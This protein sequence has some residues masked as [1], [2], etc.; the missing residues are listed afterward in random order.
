MNKSEGITI[1]EKTG[2]EQ[3]EGVIIRALESEDEDT[4]MAALKGV[5]VCVCV[6]CLCVLGVCVMRVCVLYV[7]C[8]CVCVLYV[9][10]R[11]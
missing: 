7:L 1:G 4:K 5:S 11:K 3:I 10:C 2:D 6:V 8:V 9:L